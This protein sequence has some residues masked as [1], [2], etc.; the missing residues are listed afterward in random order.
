M[1]TGNRISTH[2]TTLVLFCILLSSL[3][4]FTLVWSAFHQG[5]IPHRLAAAAIVRAVGASYGDSRPHIVAVEQD[6]AEN[7]GEPMYTIRATGMFH[8]GQTAFRC[9]YISAMADRMD[10]WYAAGSA[11]PLACRKPD[12]TDTWLMLDITAFSH[13]ETRPH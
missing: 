6:T 1:A 9:M 10:V 7:G 8:S 12:S 13:P 5:L 11:Q 3:A 2:R 4:W